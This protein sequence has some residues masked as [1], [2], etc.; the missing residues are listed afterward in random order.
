MVLQF[1][2]YSRPLTTTQPIV[3]FVCYSSFHHSHPP[4]V[5]SFISGSFIYLPPSLY[6]SVLLSTCRSFSISFLSNDGP[7]YPPQEQDQASCCSSHDSSRTT[8][9]RDQGCTTS[10]AKEGHC[11]SHSTLQL[12]TCC[13][14]LLALSNPC[15]TLPVGCSLVHRGQ[16]KS[17]INLYPAKGKVMAMSAATTSLEW[18]D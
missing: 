4:A 13:E 1:S 9:S 6:L 11:Q 10:K 5:P 14:R 2:S 12:P 15:W 3:S 17:T 8:E 18:P 7:C 16:I